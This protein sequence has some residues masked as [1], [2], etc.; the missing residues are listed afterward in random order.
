MDVVSC[1]MEAMDAHRG[2]AEVVQCGLGFLHNLALAPE[3]QVTPVIMHWQCCGREWVCWRLV[4]VQVD[5]YLWSF[6]A[7]F[8]RCFVRIES[9]WR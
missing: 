9:R 5:A 4:N 2:V 7:C 3:N 8:V 6:L 1:A